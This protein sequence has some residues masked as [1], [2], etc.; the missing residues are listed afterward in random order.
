M[1]RNQSREISIASLVLLD[2]IQTTVLIIVLPFV[3]FGSTHSLELWFLGVTPISAGFALGILG[4]L[5]VGRQVDRRSA[6]T[7]LQVLQVF[8]ALFLVGTI[9]SALAGH[10]FAL[11]LFGM[12]ALAFSRSVGPAKDKIRS[13]YISSGRRT[14]FNGQIRRYFL[15]ANEIAGA[16]CTIT[17][18]II[19]SHYWPLLFLVSFVCTVTSISVAVSLK[20]KSTQQVM[21]R[22]SMPQKIG[23]NVRLPLVMGLVV[24]GILGLSSA[25]PTIGLSAW[26]STRD[27]FGPWLVT[28]VGLIDLTVDFF[29]IRLLSTTLEKR[30]ELWKII[31]RVGGTLMIFAILGTTVAVNTKEHILQL[32][33]L[34]FSMVCATLVFSISA[35][36]AMEIQFGFGA[37]ENR[38]RIASYT[39]LSSAVAMTIA[40][41]LTP[42][43]FLGNWMTVTILTLTGVVLF[44]LPSKLI[45]AWT[46][47]SD[48]SH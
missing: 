26:I 17:M 15:V 32:A 38:G 44:L 39:R 42:G 40:A 21:A 23:K 9:V 43:V 10:F 28:V 45:T 12:L 18:T 47:L 19:P 4:A 20:T 33:I 5:L 8:Q 25:L 41:W 11:A 36:L 35:M 1:I 34:L 13:E 6:L 31:H 22:S 7:V 2:G 29:F 3:I 30:P 48:S 24:V 46:S 14:L 37:Q 16:L 27:V